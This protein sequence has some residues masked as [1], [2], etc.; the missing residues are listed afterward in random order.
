MDRVR[1]LSCPLSFVGESAQEIMDDVPTKSGIHDAAVHELANI[2][3]YII[4]S[5]FSIHQLRIPTL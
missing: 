2:F 5:R 3:P 1:S 4:D